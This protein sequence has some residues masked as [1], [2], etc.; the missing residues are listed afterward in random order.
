MNLFIAF[1]VSNLSIVMYVFFISHH[2]LNPFN[3]LFLYESY[4][5]S[6][7]THRHLQL[8]LNNHNYHPRII[9]LYHFIIMLFYK[10]YLY[11]PLYIESIYFLSVKPIYLN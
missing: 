7:S 6:S 4:L 8:P 10:D 1:P 3:Q 11:I 2:R 5:D 9:M